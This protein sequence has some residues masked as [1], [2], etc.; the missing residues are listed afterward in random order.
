MKI[1]LAIDGSISSDAAVREIATHPWPRGSVVKVISAFRLPFIPT[2]ETRSLP[3]SDHSRIESAGIE[4]ANTSITRALTRLRSE[5]EELFEIESEMIIG[6]AREVILDEAS[7][8]KA[9]L[10]VLG[11]RGLGGFKRFL[12]G[13]VALGVL[14]HA[15]C[16]V[17]IVRGTAAQDREAAMKILL[18]VD[19]S[20]CGLAAAEEVAWRP[21]PNGSSVKIIYVAEHPIILPQVIQTLPEAALSQLQRAASYAIDKAAAQFTTC[22]DDR[23]A[24][25]NEILH[26]NPKKAIL[27]EAEKWGA[28]LI[29]LGSHG[30]SAVERFLLGSVSRTVAT[31]AKCSVEVVR[32]PRR[33]SSGL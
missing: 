24:V 25:A 13:S 26:G 12:L 23:L 2:E 3:Q 5:K 20:L 33:E 14:T 21:W 30:M 31:H 27:D 8:W 32:R 22:A 29:V 11:S 19:G 7:S 28:D 16:S 1:L 18:A 4:Y 6:D 17:R 15:S 10:I 9:D